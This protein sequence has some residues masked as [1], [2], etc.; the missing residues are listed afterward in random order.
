MGSQSEILSIDFGSIE[1]VEVKYLPTPYD[2][3]KI[4]ELPPLPEN[5]PTTFS[6]DMDGMEKQYDGHT[7]CKTMTTNIKNDYGLKFRKSACTSH[8]QCSNGNCDFID[9]NPGKVNSTEWA[10]LT[11]S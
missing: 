4:F 10:G 11:L 2:G 8:L 5:I 3:D 9:R 1:H 7:W 6:G